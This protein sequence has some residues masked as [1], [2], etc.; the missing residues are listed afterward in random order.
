MFLSPSQLLAFDEQVRLFTLSE[1]DISHSLRE[2]V[3]YDVVTLA[4]SVF[5]TPISLIGL[6]EAEQVNY[7]AARG[8][9]G[10]RTQPRQEALC[11]LVVQR[12]K[13][14]VFTDLTQPHQYQ[15]LTPV[16]LRNVERKHYRFYAGIPL[17]MPNQHV[18]GTLCILDRQPRY[19]NSAERRVL[20]IMASLVERIVVV[21]HVCLSSA[22][23]GKDSWRAV[24]QYV[25]TELR[26][27]ITVIRKLQ[28][29]QPADS[30]GEPLVLHAVIHHLNVL[31]TVLAEPLPG[32][33]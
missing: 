28:S 10:V 6:V 26:D 12:N 19:L 24:Y 1:Y 17:R 21:R 18:I 8:L 2:P 11:A 16:A 30:S 22:W 25:S 33:A 31:G 23:L 15:Q 7:K 20:E 5:R 27:I 32:L 4:T 29:E 3:F 9:G 13:A 14:V